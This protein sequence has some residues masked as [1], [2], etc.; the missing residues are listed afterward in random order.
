[1]DQFLKDAREHEELEAELR[2]F[3]AAEEDES[4]LKQ[5]HLKGDTLRHTLMHTVGDETHNVDKVVRAI[6]RTDAGSGRRG[7]Y[8]FHKNAVDVSAEAD[9][10]FPAAIATKIC[11]T[12]VKK[13]Q[14]LDMSVL[15]LS[16]KLRGNRLPDELF[17]WLLDEICV[18][19]SGLRRTQYCDRLL[20]CTP[21]DFTRHVNRG[22][23]ERLFRRLG[24]SPDIN[25]LDS[26]LATVE[27]PKVAYY[28]R[29]W[30]CLHTL[31]DVLYDIS[32]NLGGEAIEYC[33]QMLLRI[34]VDDEILRHPE[35]S[36]SH[37]RLLARLV[38]NY[39]R[40]MPLKWDEF[41]R[42]HAP[43]RGKLFSSRTAN[44]RPVRGHV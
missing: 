23:L 36:S 37:P 33:V 31:L 42:I 32:H 8:F 16:L 18:E 25:N 7:W 20:Q 11:G 41:V 1:M 29:R 2:R 34:A 12:R 17:A 5:E 40:M 24:A 19:E 13:S 28:Q 4:L 39:R 6:E 10:S 26:E 3:K 38:G 14:E 15:D 21:D 35:V 44:F 27:C 30:D 9:D 22:S 43:I